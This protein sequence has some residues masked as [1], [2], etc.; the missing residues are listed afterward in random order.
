MFARLMGLKTVSPQE[1]S[2][3]LGTGSATAIDVNAPASWRE[4]HVPGA[5]NLD[6]VNFTAG[7]LPGDKSDLVVFYCS[8]PLC[9]KAPNAAKR[10]QK[11]GFSNVKVLSAGIQGWIKDGQA[12]ERGV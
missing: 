2:R 12:T 9:R 4:A 8:N 1:L 10:A 3:L 6:P 5:K 11:F 7:E